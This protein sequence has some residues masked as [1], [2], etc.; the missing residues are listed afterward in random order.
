MKV[1][2]VGA[3]F[4]G[5]AAAIRLQERRHEVLLLERRGILGGRATSYV[6]APSGDEVDN[7]THLMLGAYRETCA[8]AEPATC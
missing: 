3:G 7:G 5:L 6:D 1:V 8:A 2:V 4:A